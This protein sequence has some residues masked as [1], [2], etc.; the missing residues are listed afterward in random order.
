MPFPAPRM[1][2]FLP[3]CLVLILA[4]CSDSRDPLGPSRT[5]GATELSDAVRAG[6]N[7]ALD[8][9]SRLKPDLSN[10]WPND[11]GRSWLYRIAERTWGNLQLDP[12]T[13]PTAAQVPPAPRL[14]DVAALLRS[15]PIG[16]NPVL[17]TAGYR[18]RF[19]GIKT[20]QSGAVGQNLETTVLEEVGIGPAAVRVGPTAVR[21]GTAA[22][23]PGF[24]RALSIARPD[25]T[26]KL[27][28]KWGS[29]I[30][31]NSADAAASVDPPN[32]LFGYAWEKTSEYIGSYGDLNTQLAWKYLVANLKP[33]SSFVMQLVPDLANDVFLYARVLPGK[34]SDTEFGTFRNVVRMLYLIDFGVGTLTDV[35]GNSLGYFRVYSYGTIDYAPGVGPVASYERD[36]VQPGRPLDP[37][38]YDQSIGLVATEAGAPI[39]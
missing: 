13:Y 34:S 6:S 36:L 16:A 19:N 8:A 18:M 4:G 24:L 39:P 33:G 32:F 15:H 29:Q 27:A 17:S 22:T 9:Q 5:P 3:L 38:I 12:R 1:S 14:T 10:I 11:D 25:L 7:P 35:D 31:T 26:R 28:A 23:P 2:P 30:R 20:T 21:A 37:G